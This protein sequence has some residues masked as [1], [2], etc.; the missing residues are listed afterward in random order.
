M[1][2]G[3][4]ER[5]LGGGEG[6]ARAVTRLGGDARVLSDGSEDFSLLAPYM[7][8]EYDLS[9]LDRIPEHR[10]ELPIGFLVAGGA[11]SE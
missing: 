11:G 4:I 6:L 5:R 2:R 7:V 1:E 9:K 8:T 3:P 10:D